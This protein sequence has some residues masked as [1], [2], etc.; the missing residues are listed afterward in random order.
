MTGVLIVGLI[1]VVVLALI[2]M[3]VMPSYLRRR[4]RGGAP[5]DSWEVS[6]TKAERQQRV[7][8]FDAVDRGHFTGTN[9]RH[10]PGF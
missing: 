2:R 10:G 3:T 7:R 6:E 5:S 9:G 8:D 4:R 1:F